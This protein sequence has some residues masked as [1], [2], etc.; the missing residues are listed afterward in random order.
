MEWVIEGHNLGKTYGSKTVLEHVD[1]N[2]A[3]GRIVGLIGPNGAGKTTLLK[4]ILGL[5]L[6]KA[7]C[8][9][10]GITPIASAPNY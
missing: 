2:I 6:S 9:S 7:S 1:L 8:A 3:P 4:G 10:W 5:T